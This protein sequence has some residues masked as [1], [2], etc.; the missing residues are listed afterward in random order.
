MPLKP[1]NINDAFKDIPNGE[2]SNISDLHWER[3][4][5]DY[6]NIRYCEAEREYDELERKYNEWIEAFKNDSPV[7]VLNKLRE[8]ERKN[9]EL[10]IKN[11][12]LL[13]KKCKDNY[14]LK[15][16]QIE[17]LKKEAKSWKISNWSNS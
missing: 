11:K 8:L 10:N 7:I 3:K 16:E 13:K 9:E 6:L 15:E 17:K 1:L 4:R 5:F 2:F 14:G 12:D